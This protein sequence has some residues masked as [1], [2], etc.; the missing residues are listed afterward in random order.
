MSDTF[1]NILPYWYRPGTH[2]SVNQRLFKY[3][4]FILKSEQDCL[5]RKNSLLFKTLQIQ[6]FLPYDLQN[7]FFNV[8]HGLGGSTALRRY[9]FNL[10]HLQP[11]QWTLFIHLARHSF[12][13]MVGYI[14][15]TPGV[16]RYSGRYNLLLSQLNVALH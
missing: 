6:Q 1:Y 10:T 14:S 15:S 3:D 11:P 16:K 13:K 4:N 7:V 12:K 8:S 5:K 9:Q 2:V